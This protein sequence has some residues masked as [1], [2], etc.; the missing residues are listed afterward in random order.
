MPRDGEFEYLVPDGVKWLEFILELGALA[1]GILALFFNNLWFL[2]IIGIVVM[3]GVLM[4]SYF[5]E[6]KMEN[7]KK[8][9]AEAFLAQIRWSEERNRNRRN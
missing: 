3:L 2:A 4:R 5:W 9:R 7:E 8:R 1:C 6:G